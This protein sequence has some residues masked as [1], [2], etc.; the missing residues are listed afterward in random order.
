VNG[1]DWPGSYDIREQRQSLVEIIDKLAAAHYNTIYFQVRSRADAMY[2]SKYE[3]W[4]QQLTGILGKDPGWDPLALVL[5]EGHARGLEV[6][7]WFN[8]FYARSGKALPPQSTPPHVILKH[9]EW[10]RLAE[11]EWWFDPGVPAARRYVL[12]VAMDLVRHYDIDGIHFDFLRYPAKLFPDESSYR[13]Y[14]GSLPKDEWR[15]ENI[16]MFVRAFYDSAMA[17]KPML[18]VGSAPIGIY[19]NFPNVSGMQSYSDVY[20][21]SRLWL[22][23]GK[24]DYLVPQTY[25]PFG[26]R[27]GNPDFGEIAKEWAGHTYGREVYPGIGAYKPEV[28]DQIPRLIDMSRSLGFHGN[29]F[30]R[31]GSIERALEAGGRYNTLAI[32]PPMKWKDSIPPNPPASFA[33]TGAVRGGF[34]LQWSPPPPA[35]DGDEARSYDVYRSTAS[36]VDVD[37][38][39]NLVAI[40][41]HGAT[42]LYDTV[43]HPAAARYYYAVS[44]VD[45]GNNESRPAESSALLPEIVEVLGGIA[46]G[47][48]LGKNYPDPASSVIFVPYELGEE[49]PVKLT[50]VDEH[51]RAVADLVRASQPPGRYIASGDLSNLKNGVYS[52]KLVAGALSASRAFRI[53]N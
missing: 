14:G 36:P 4:S 40:I 43:S 19:T 31:Y 39:N 27:A 47:F 3:P 15:R 1:L 7:A 18:K 2:H 32:V 13:R 22:R 46:P 25:W 45:K 33:V 10:V 30:F 12:A 29:S 42:Q 53:Q 26:A 37:D 48:R 21:D 5:E 34:R 23:E 8:T 16:N 11:G 35:R 17:L 20:Q 41:R 44:A 6:H 52:L 38:P 28:F 49:A 24:Q 9:P 50:I 51:D